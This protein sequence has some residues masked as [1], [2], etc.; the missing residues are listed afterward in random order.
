MNEAI[1]VT[2]ASGN[3]GGEVVR[4]LLE[5]GERV[6][7]ALRNPAGAKV[8]T[9]G[10]E[11]VRFDYHDPRT[12]V[13]ALDGASR[14]YVVL[15]P[16]DP[17][18]PQYFAPFL[19]AAK[20]VGVGQLVLTSAIGV[21]QNDAAPLRQVELQI[22][23]SGIPYTHLRPNFFMEN[24]STGFLSPMIREAG[25]ISLTAGD[26]KTSFISVVDIAAVAVAALTGQGHHGKAYPLTGP[27]GLSHAEVAAMISS[28][29]DRQIGYRAID[30]ETMRAAFKEGGLPESAIKYAS[31][32]YQLVRAGS[33]A[34]VTDD[35]KRV[36]GREPVDFTTFT[37]V[38]AKCWRD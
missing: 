35:V 25:E 34:G 15:P 27:E 1:L 18:A 33:V 20:Q 16:L 31:V 38:N 19:Q 2:G 37:R 21:D 28:A 22:E 36:L 6:R 5:R 4:Q 8:A 23:A 32:L 29:A 11:A 9:E 26:E 14:I 13:P 3:L 30:D 17:E 7:A 24:F 10:L 12:F